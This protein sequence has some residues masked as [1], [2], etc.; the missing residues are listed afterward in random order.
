MS[1]HGSYD[2][3]PLKPAESYFWPK[4]DKSG[5]CWMWT[6]AR[7]SE[8]RYG[9][10]AINQRKH[11]AHRAA[12]FFATGHLPVVGEVICHR[13]DN[14][15]CV[16]FDHLFLGT[17]ADNLRDMREKGRDEATQIART[18]VNNHNARLNPEAVR[19]ARRRRAQGQSVRDIATVYGVTPSAMRQ[20]IDRLTWKHVA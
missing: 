20:A 4:V 5:D 11:Q 14:T 12:W 17:Q 6:A 9:A 13:C 15:L 10:F 8:G 3:P 7:T 18:G 19:D 16:R 1:R 2:K